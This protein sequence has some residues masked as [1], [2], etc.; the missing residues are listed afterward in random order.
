MMGTRKRKRECKPN[1]SDESSREQRESGPI[2]SHEEVLACAKAEGLT[3]VP[4]HTCATG[5]KGVSHLKKNLFEASYYTTREQRLVSSILSE[6][7]SH[8]AAACEFSA[9]TVSV[10]TVAGGTV[11]ALVPPEDTS[12]APRKGR[13][14]VTIGYYRTASEAAL[15]FAR[16]LGPAASADAAAKARPPP[17]LPLSASE[18]LERAAAE[19][20]VLEKGYASSGYRG[21]V[22]TR[23]KFISTA[24]AGVQL[25]SYATAEEASLMRARHLARECECAAVL[26]LGAMRNAP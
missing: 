13:R 12:A 23:G 20:L 25:G 6:H 1:S 3:L 10:P 16:H 22:Y 24:S 17:P 15:A 9:S 4:S 14:N 21:V 8:T 19:N 2:M 26:S 11:A 5:F 18:A 7:A